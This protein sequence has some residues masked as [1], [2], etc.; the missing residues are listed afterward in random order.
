MLLAGVYSIRRGYINKIL[1]FVE[2]DVIYRRY[3][4]PRQYWTQV[5][6]VFLISGCVFF[7]A[8]SLCFGLIPL[9]SFFQ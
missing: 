1:G 9:G 2:E 6:V 8:Y 7:E 5:I 4:Q 3:D